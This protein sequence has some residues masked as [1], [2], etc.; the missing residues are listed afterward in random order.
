MQRE[1]FKQFIFTVHV[2]EIAGRNGESL[3]AEML[4][5]PLEPLN[6]LTVIIEMYVD[7]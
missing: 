1:K 7:L 3:L 4:S 6:L 2:V 5:S